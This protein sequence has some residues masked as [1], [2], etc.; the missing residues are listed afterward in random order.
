VQGARI[1]SVVRDAE[2]LVIGGN[3]TAVVDTTAN[4]IAAWNPATG[5]WSSLG[6]GCNATVA[7]LA[8]LPSGVLVAAGEFWS[9]GGITTNYIAQWDGTSWSALGA[10]LS[11]PASCLAVEPSGNLL[12]GGY[13]QN[14]GATPARGVA[15]WNGIAWSPLGNGP[16]SFPNDLTVLPNG[17]VVTV[18]RYG[19]VELWNGVTWQQIGL[20]STIVSGSWPVPGSVEAVVWA[21]GR[22]WVA[23]TF[24]P[25]E[26]RPDRRQRH[27]EWTDLAGCQHPPASRQVV[28]VAAQR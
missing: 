25:H 8:V 11:G 9:A 14:A 20:S 3:F 23:G 22:L 6:T 2:L 10:G 15:R 12:V 28:L 1:L 19:A 27:L 24:T 17:D 4:C 5:A 26:R 18:S 13:F 16:T 21:F 7:D